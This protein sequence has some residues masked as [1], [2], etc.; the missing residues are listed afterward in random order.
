VKKDSGGRFVDQFTATR[1]QVTCEDTRTEEVAFTI[2]RDTRI[3]DDGSFQVLIHRLRFWLVIDGTVR[4][5]RADGTLEFKVPGFTDDPIP[6]PQT[7][8]T[9]ELTWDMRRDRPITRHHR[10]E[11]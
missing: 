1:V 4:F 3:Q 2:G 9:G 5:G 8:T 6:Q 7:C 11:S 10:V